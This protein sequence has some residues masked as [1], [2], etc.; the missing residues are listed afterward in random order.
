MHEIRGHSLGHSV[1]RFS[2][3]ERQRKSL[4]EG[5]ITRFLTVIV[6]TPCQ[7]LQYNLLEPLKECDDCRWEVYIYVTNIVFQ[8]ILFRILD[9]SF[10]KNFI[11]QLEQI[12]VIKWRL[13]SLINRV[14]LSELLL[15]ASPRGFFTQRYCERY[16]LLSIVKF[17]Q[18][19]TS[20]R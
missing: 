1:V 5:L 20:I 8:K 17:T 13:L 11:L 10:I 7:P 16:S 4:N 2:T 6:S 19:L 15:T 18:K 9:C 3:T 12:R 14:P